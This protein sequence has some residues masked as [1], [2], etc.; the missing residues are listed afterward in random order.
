DPTGKDHPE[1]LGQMWS[2]GHNATIVNG[3]SRIGYMSGGQSAR[4]VDEDMADTIT[5]KAVAF[6][7]DHKDGPFFLFF[8][9]HDI[10]VPRVPHQRFRGGSEMGLRGDVIAQMDWCVGRILD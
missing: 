9:T 4:W 5:T 7:E 8:A 3:I 6:I 2:H 1:L 10:H